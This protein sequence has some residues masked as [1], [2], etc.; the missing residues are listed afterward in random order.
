MQTFETI[1]GQKAI[2]EHF[3]TAIATG[4]VSHAYILNGEEG[5]GKMALAEAFSLTLFFVSSEISALPLN[6]FD[7]AILVIPKAS[8][9]SW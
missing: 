5:M 4:K 7:T 3:T 1:L 6:A 8:A 9:M 2:K